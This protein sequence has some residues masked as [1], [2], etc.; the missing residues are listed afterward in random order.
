[1]KN[2]IKHDCPT[3]K[4]SLLTD[5]KDVHVFVNIENKWILFINTP[6][7][8]DNVVLHVSHCPYCGLELPIPSNH[9]VS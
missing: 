5:G 1:M 3:R 9:D 6:F 4:N 7:T 8:E 2:V